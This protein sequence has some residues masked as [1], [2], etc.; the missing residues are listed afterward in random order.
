MGSS[1]KMCLVITNQTQFGRAIE[2]SGKKE[3][4]NAFVLFTRRTHCNA[5]LASSPNVLGL[6]II[7][8]L[9]GL[10]RMTESQI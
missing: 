1:T 3:A 8:S 9:K 5:A 10:W 7:I 2:Q 6:T 4:D